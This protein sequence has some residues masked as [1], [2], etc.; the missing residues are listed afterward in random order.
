MKTKD[1]IKSTVLLFAGV[2]MLFTACKKPETPTPAPV[3]VAEQPFV[4]SMKVGDESLLDVLGNFGE[5]Y[6]RY[7]N[8]LDIK[9]IADLGGNTFDLNVKISMFDVSDTMIVYEDKNGV[10]EK[11]DNGALKLIASANPKK[12]DISLAVN[13]NDT[14]FTEVLD[15]NVSVT[16]PAGT[17]SCTKIKEY[18]SENSDYR[19]TYMCGK[20]MTKMQQYGYDAPPIIFELRSSNH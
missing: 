8:A 1:L 6:K 12:G 15:M 19:I 7:E 2:S 14:T 3:P 20:G 9:N 18:H 10:Y 5:G 16:V 11:L 17:F 13:G 4:S